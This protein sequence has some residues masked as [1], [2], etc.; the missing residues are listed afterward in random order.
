M[1]ENETNGNKIGK[2]IPQ[3]ELEAHPELTHEIMKKESRLSKYMK[4]RQRTRIP[5][6]YIWLLNLPLFTN[7]ILGFSII[8]GLLFLYFGVM[9]ALT[10]IGLTEQN[11]WAIYDVMWIFGWEGSAITGF[12]LI[13]IGII[14]LWSIPYYFL[15]N[16]QK[17]DSYLIIGVGLGELFGIVYIFIILADLL[18][19]LLDF[20]S[21][22]EVN[23]PETYFYYPVILALI[24]APLFRVLSIRHIV[25]PPSEKEPEDYSIQQ[26]RKE[27]KNWREDYKKQNEE[28][29]RKW[30]ERRGHRRHK[31]RRRW[32]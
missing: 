2:E 7:L 24:A 10:I 9:G 12:A 30:S 16:T 17:A 14:M 8:L 32:E 28:Y 11:A 22:N 3:D 5:A 15:N 25:L 4:N 31:R 18:S 21:T 6:R 26:Y 27:R 20:L 1:N 19:W 13:V 23:P 29:F